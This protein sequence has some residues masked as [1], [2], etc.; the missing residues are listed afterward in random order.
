MRADPPL[1]G[2]RVSEPR[3]VL[4]AGVGVGDISPTQAVRLAG[5]IARDPAVPALVIADPLQVRAVALDDGA[6]TA[7]LLVFDLVGMSVAFSAPLRVV[8]AAATGVPVKR[9]LT[10]CT[11][12]HA[13]PDTVLGMDLYAG[14]AEQVA[15]AAVVASRAALAS[16]VPVS[17]GVAEIDV[18]T[19]LAINRRGRPHSPRLQLVDLHAGG[20]RLASL[21]GVGIHPVTHGPDVHVVT[22]DWVGHCRTA[23]EASLGGTTVVVSG[24]LGDVNP[25]GGDGYDRGGGGIELARDVGIAVAEL[26]VSA[27]VRTDDVGSRL[28]LDHATVELPV[29]DAELSRLVSGG[30]DS[31]VTE[32]FDWAIGELR[33]VSMPGEPLSGFAAAVSRPGPMLT[34]GLAPSWQ[35]YLP[36]PDSFSG[37]YEDELCLGAPA[38]RLLLDALG[39]A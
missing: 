16:L 6:A 7:L 21:V 9:V 36:H 26:A 28:V 38:M 23:V 19:T 25:P 35:G 24:P 34:V 32:L 30:S 18:P 8:V 37:G 1:G 10:S 2:G 20:G 27:A 13:G 33:L 3:A 15:A 4:R 14:Y 11:H 31:V 39:A 22:A 5:F 17:V 12:T 29:A